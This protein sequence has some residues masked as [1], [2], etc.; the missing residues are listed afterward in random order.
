MRR[1]SVKTCAALKG[2]YARISGKRGYAFLAAS[3]HAVASHADEEHMNA[4]GHEHLAAAI[5]KK[6][7][8]SVLL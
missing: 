1:P 8:E 6:L 2:V 4:E 5:W 7:R 3:D